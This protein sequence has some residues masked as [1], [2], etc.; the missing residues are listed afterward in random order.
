MTRVVL[1]GGGHSHVEV[2]REFARRPQPGLRIS[3]ISQE[4]MTPYSG[5]LPGVIAGHYPAAAAHI[6]LARLCAAAGATLH[7]DRVTALELDARRVYGASGADQVW[8]LLSLN[9]GSTPGLQSIDGAA[10]V[11]I[12]VKPIGNFLPRW[13]QFL[14]RIRT[15]ST[16]AFRLA[17]V[18]AGAGGVELALAI[19]YRLRCVEGFSQLQLTLIDA[20][21]SLLPQ[22]TPRL[23]QRLAKILDQR[24]IEVHTNTRVATARAGEL[25]TSAARVIPADEILWVTP[26]SAP[27]WPAS[28]GLATD[29][30]GFVRVDEQL[31]SVSHPHIFAAGDVASFADRCLPKA[32][33]FA[34]RQGPVLADN[35]ARAALGQPLIS[36]RPQGRFLTLISTGNRYAVAARGSWTA[37]GAWAWRWK[38]WLDRR[39]IGRFAGN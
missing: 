11:G 9:S 22:H 7:H 14:T 25:V 8:D 5:M 39:F 12:P 38:D 29:A 21:P 28:A 13:E 34:V 10:G 3:V 19:D 16:Q 30:G 4:V 15:S 2:L 6:D 27:D 1:I 32:G 26:A 23:G 35:L 37:Q 36:Y 17:I 33:V 20:A 24:N 18:G 31:R